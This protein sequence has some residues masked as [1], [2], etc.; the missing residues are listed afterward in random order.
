[1]DG[2]RTVD[3]TLRQM[4]DS[5]GCY[6]SICSHC[7]TDGVIGLIVGWVGLV[8]RG[9]CERVRVNLVWM[10]VREEREGEGRERKEM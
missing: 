7:H 2:Y 5:L 8:S 1:M 9:G 3:D 4:P 10:G 6:V